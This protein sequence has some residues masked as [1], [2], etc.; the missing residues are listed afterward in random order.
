[1][2]GNSAGGARPFR[3]IAEM[4]REGSVPNQSPTRAPRQKK[5]PDD[6]VG[7]KTPNFYFITLER[8]LAK[9]SKSPRPVS[10]RNEPAQTSTSESPMLMH[11]S[12][13]I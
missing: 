13:F 7:D 2:N 8:D 5:A 6:H 4:I 9:N 11:T 10:N 12:G 3:A 1:M